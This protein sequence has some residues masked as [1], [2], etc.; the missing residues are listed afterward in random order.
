MG[1]AIEGVL[2]VVFVSGWW[3]GA[4]CSHPAGPLLH[5]RF[6]RLLVVAFAVVTFTGSQTIEGGDL[7][8]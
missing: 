6:Q 8:L 4:T 5:L 1:I 7:W 3:S 2:F